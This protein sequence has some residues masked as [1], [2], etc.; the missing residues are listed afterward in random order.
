MDT[1]IDQPSDADFMREAL[2][3]AQEKIAKQNDRMEHLEVEVAGR[4]PE[5]PADV[6]PL[7]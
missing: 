2:R 7:R 1:L 3:L 5:H 6:G 4:K